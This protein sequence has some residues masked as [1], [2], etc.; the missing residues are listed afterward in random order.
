MSHG[1]FSKLFVHFSVSGHM[2]PTGA[3]DHPPA[4]RPE[5]VKFVNNDT[6][7]TQAR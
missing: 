6:L 2:T 1:C 7:Q 4:P 3:A 5:T